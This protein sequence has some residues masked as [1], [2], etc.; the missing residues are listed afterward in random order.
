[1]TL[2]AGPLISPLI[3]IPLAAIG[4]VLFAAHT[5]VIQRADMPQ[6][7]RKVRMAIDVLSMFVVAAVA[8]G[9]SI[10]NPA[11]QKAFVLCWLLVVGLVGVSL[12]LAMVDV[13]ITLR[14]AMRERREDARRSA[15]ELAAAVLKA[16]GERASSSGSSQ[17][18]GA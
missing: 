9:A 18:R 15:D 1:M 2:A 7:R 13:V 5:L 3:A 12:L 6:S 16:R 10:V 8:Y 4:M 11:D 17:G 14:L